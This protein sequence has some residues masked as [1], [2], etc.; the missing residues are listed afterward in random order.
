MG[1]QP[2]YRKEKETAEVS[3]KGKCNTAHSKTNNQ[4]VSIVY[5]SKP[6][7]NDKRRKSTSIRNAVVCESFIVW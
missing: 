3:L 6:K 7:K 5:C 2:Y 1:L 4:L